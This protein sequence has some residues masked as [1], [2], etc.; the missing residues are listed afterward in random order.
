VEVQNTCEYYLVD[1]LTE[2]ENASCPD[3]YSG[4][5]V[6][7]RFYELWSDGSKRNYSNWSITQDNCTQKESKLGPVS[8]KISPF[9]NE[10]IGNETPKNWTGE[11]IK[12]LAE[13]LADFP[14]GIYVD[15]E[16]QSLMSR[17]IM[18]PDE[19]YKLSSDG[20]NWFEMRA[21]WQPHDW[22]S[23]YNYP[24]RGQKHYI[25]DIKTSIFV[26]KI[27]C[28]NKDSIY[29]GR[30]GDCLRGVIVKHQNNFGFK[31]SRFN[32]DWP[33]YKESDL[34]RPNIVNDV[35]IYFE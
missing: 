25:I 33:R 26:H 17:I 30:N 29:P 18:L 34:A 10:S 28:Y 16:G 19:W 2:T 31:Y 13:I 12:G 7:A 27:D 11:P 21:K 24:R 4:S 32:L 3:G 14:S 20:K 23:E 8:M 15:K 5:K 35:T 6:R 22:T 1:T 9:R